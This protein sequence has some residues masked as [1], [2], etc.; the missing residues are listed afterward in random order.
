MDSSASR[1]F[2]AGTDVLKA[3]SI[4]V[5]PTKSVPSFGPGINSATTVAMV[6]SRLST[7]KYGA[8]LVKW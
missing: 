5:P 8:T 4:S 7:A 1:T 3:T 2:W 6:T